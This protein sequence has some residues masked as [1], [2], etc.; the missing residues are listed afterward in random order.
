M[1][2]LRQSY[3]K[4]VFYVFKCPVILAST[5]ILLSTAFLMIQL[6]ALGALKIA[7]TETDII[8]SSSDKQTLKAYTCRWL[9]T[10]KYLLYA[11]F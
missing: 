8:M 11:S 7:K 3:H 4:V 2:L 1:N 9:N 10:V 5:I 6:S